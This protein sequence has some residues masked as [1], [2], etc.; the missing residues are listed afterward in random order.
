MNF[1]K[2]AARIAANTRFNYDKYEADLSYLFEGN[3][4]ESITERIISTQYKNMAG[5]FH[6][7]LNRGEEFEMTKKM[8]ELNVIKKYLD[9]HFK[10]YESIKSLKKARPV[11]PPPSPTPPKGGTDNTP[12]GARKLTPEELQKH[13]KLIKESRERGGLFGNLPPDYRGI[14]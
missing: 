13:N 3:I 10:E 14:F 7:D 12:P 4:P 9:D 11:R 8:A 5:K 2:I 6:P 1:T